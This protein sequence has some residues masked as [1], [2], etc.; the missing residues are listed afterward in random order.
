[1]KNIFRFD[2]SFNTID[3]LVLLEN[4]WNFILLNQS[5]VLL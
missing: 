2:F 1:M 3:N 5:A 4:S